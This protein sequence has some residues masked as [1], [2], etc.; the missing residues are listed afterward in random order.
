MPIQRHNV[1]RVVL[2][3]AIY[4]FVLGACSNRPHKE[5]LRLEP[6]Q[7]HYI[8][9]QGYGTVI[10]FVHGIFGDGT[11]T[12]TNADT[13]KYWPDLLTT[14]DVFAK[15]DIYVHSYFTPFLTQSYT[16]DQLIENMRAVFDKDAIFTS[17]EE[18]IFL[19]HSMGGLIVRG[20]LKRYQENAKK[21]PFIYFFSTPTDGSHI[22]QMT[23]LL[24]AN[25]QLGGMV[26]IDSNEY[27]LGMQ[28][29][30]RAMT[31]RIL[32]VCAY[33][34]LDTYKFR[35]VDERSATSLCDGPV[36]PF[37]KDHIQIVKPSGSDDLIYSVFQRAYQTRPPSPG[38]QLIF[39]AVVPMDVHPGQ[40]VSVVV[41]RSSVSESGASNKGVISIIARPPAVEAP[42]NR[43]TNQT[44]HPDSKK[45]GRQEPARERKSSQATAA[46]ASISADLFIP[47]MKGFSHD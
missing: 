19:C 24:S 31:A 10:V 5:H 1:L 3:L 15:T 21:V 32:S 22:A 38:S 40:K 33:E 45:K 27:L 9:R 4:L 26:P 7:S 36:T 16:I 8:R 41:P 18:V 46:Q 11:S 43:A 39:E 23:A 6:Q 12:W 25:P 42:T 37:A 13:K 47:S 17:H 29:D 20:Y 35:I 2:S 28:K 34:M 30:W 14:D 44:I